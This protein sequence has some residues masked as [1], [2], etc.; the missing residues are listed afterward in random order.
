MMKRIK[1]ILTAAAVTASLVGVL[2]PMSAQAARFTNDA[3]NNEGR[4]CSSNFLGFPAW[5]KGLP[6]KEGTCD[7]AVSERVVQDESGAD[8]EEVS[9]QELNA[10]I[11]RIVLNIIDIALRIVGYAAVG[12]IIY[13]GFK[14]LTSSGS[15]DRITSGRKIIT[16]ALIG[17]V[18]SFMSVAIVN[19]IANNLK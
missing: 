19:L 3:T 6:R 13:G 12:F 8:V 9:E 7:I 2:L 17:L 10:F 15:A 16:N 5:Y 18:I 4:A 11:F 14:Y 1:S